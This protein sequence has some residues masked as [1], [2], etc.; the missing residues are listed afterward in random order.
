M[1]PLLNPQQ[2][3][4][5][6][7]III[8]QMTVEDMKKK[9]KRCFKSGD[10]KEAIRHY[11]TALKLCEMYQQFNDSASIH[12]S[13]AHLHLVSKKYSIAYKHCNISILLNNNNPKV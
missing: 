8:I 7:P 11:K 4:C 2:Q 10:I 6:D 3:V 9:A 12:S 13:M 5:E 1:Y